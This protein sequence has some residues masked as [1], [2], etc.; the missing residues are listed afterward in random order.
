MSTEKFI[1]QGFNRGIVSPLA[2]ARTDLEKTGLAAE[3]MTNWVPR[4]LGSMML[5]PGGKYLGSSYSDAAARYI[6]FIFS[7]DDVAL[8][9]VTNALVRVW[10]DDAVITRGSVSTTIS[11][12]D[13]SSLTNWTD[14]DESGGTSELFA[15]RALKLTGNGSNAAIR[16]QLVSVSAADGGDEHAVKVIVERGPVNF[17]IGSFKGG[18]DYFSETELE[19]GVHS[20]AFTPDD[21]FY[22][23][24]K[25]VNKY[26][27]LVDS[28]TI[29]S[30][31]AMTITA[32]W[33][34]TDFD[35]IRY[36]QSGDILFI[37]ST[38]QQYKIERRTTRSWSVVKYYSTDGP[39]LD[40]NITETT[41]TPS[42]I[43]G[44]ITL[45]ATDPIFDQILHEGAL[46]RISSSGQSVTGSVTAENQFTNTIR[47]FG[48]GSNRIFTITRSGTWV[49]TVTLQRSLTS[50]TGPWEDVTTYTTNATIT[51]D[52]SFDNQTAW[53]RIGVKTGGFTSGTVAL[54]LSYA[55]GSVDGIVR[56][57]NSN[58]EW[59]TRTSAAD[60]DWL[61]VAW[62][63]ELS[64]FAAVSSTGV[65]NRVMTSPDGIT[66]T[67]R[68]SATDT[69][70]RAVVWS[71]SLALFAA[72]SITGAS[73][74]VMTSSDGITWTTRTSAA[75]NDWHAIA[76]SPSLALFA[77]VSDTGAGNRVM[78]STNG[79]AWTSRTSAADNSWRAIC[80]SPELALFAAVS[81]TGTGNRVMTS[82]DGI[83]W[84]SRT[85]AA[86][87]E[88]RA[89]AWSPELALFAAV[90]SSGTGNRVMTS[91]DG[92]TW[93]SRTS[94]ADNNW[95]GI[96]WS[97]ELSIFSAV[98]ITGT[99]NR[100][101]TSPD[102]ITWT[103]RTSAA[104]NSW[105]AICWSS[106]LSLFATVSYTG[107]GNRVMTTY[108]NQTAKA[109]VLT[110]L[111]DVIATDSW[112]EGA[113]SNYRD[114][115][116]AVAFSEGR[117]WWSGFN[118][119]WG[120]VSDDY[121]NY[122][123]SVEGD[124]GAID[125]TVGS[126]AVDSINWMMALQ[127]LILGTEGAELVCKSSS[128][129]EPL[130]PTAFSLRTASTQGSATVSPAALDRT[131]IYV[132]RGGTRLMEL[133][134]DIRDGE[135]G[136]ID[137]TSLNPEICRP[138]IVRTAIQRQPD[139]RIHCVRSDGKVAILV[140]D[141]VEN[142]KAWCLYETDGA[143]EDVAVLPGIEGESEDHVYYHIKR[144]FPAAT[145][146]T[147]RTPSSNNE[148]YG[149]TWS[150]ELS[151]FAVVS[152]S[153]SS[154]RVMTSPDGITWTSRVSA[155]SNNWTAIAW[156]PELSLF[157]AVSQTGTGNRV[158]TSPD[159]ITWTSRTSAA[160]NQWTAIAWSPE[161]SLFAAVSITGTGNRVMTSSD[162]ITW[163][164][165]T[166]AADNTWT[167]IA[168][169]PSLS[170]FA[171]VSITGT[172]NRVMTS[173]DGITWTS[174][175][176][177]ADNEWRAIA[178]SPE[179][180]L[181]AAVS[182]SGTGNRVMT[183]PDG[184]TWTSRTSA[185]DNNWYGITWS[186]E[187]GIFAAVGSNGTS[188]GVMTSSNGIAWSVRVPPIDNGW[189]SIAW[190]PSLSMFAAVAL[191]GTGSYLMTGSA[192]KRYLERW[193]TEAQCEGST[194][195]RNIDCAIEY[196]GT[197]TTSITGLP[198]E[199]E[200]VVVWA[201]GKDL[202]T[203]TVASGAITLSE[204]TTAA[205]TGLSYSGTWKSVKLAYTPGYTSLL[206][207]KNI[208]HLGVIL[209]NTHYQGLEYGPDF[210]TMDDLPL[211][212]NGVATAADT[213]HS[214]YDEDMFEFPGQWDTDARLCL[215]ATAPKPCNILAAVVGIEIHGKT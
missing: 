194:L 24:F 209:R 40:E 58:D 161:L 91:P 37:A 25:N 196:S 117:L 66:W 21:D 36:D 186:P 204:A 210:T 78:T 206:Q 197:S 69:S 175:T 46:F 152:L 183:S 146:W 10:V 39:W 33:S 187:L 30:S 1:L 191:S 148:W 136:S 38:K 173:S 53:Y 79:T 110:E 14:A 195:S 188:N 124:S 211:I 131:G 97:P 141:S 127:R 61:G 112:A 93:T 145:T 193:Y 89:I 56:L 201:N 119:V 12:G 77:A 4:V 214:T 44:D 190:S 9:E 83:T 139:T 135:Y 84:T 111:G 132:Q 22:I 18:D 215:R 212:E 179:L 81:I 143:V 169:S 184:I 157:A 177:A 178:W 98:S 32:P 180:S 159:G 80:W 198:H 150:P 101:M 87:N 65:G 121:Y 6:P 118:G 182:N 75:D 20:L 176:S 203:Y 64:L 192:D 31:G 60:N 74:R 107:T 181:F 207:K 172:G 126:G 123:D 102:G 63:P 140:F 200:S 52:D 116:S 72:V 151:L 108:G 189:K 144:T 153:G 158:M 104:D 28:C 164:S 165:R 208:K 3:T 155:S 82:P 122:S 50:T 43:S 45:T 13:F 142:V 199:G 174:R 86:D 11:N 48:T 129:D 95:Y 68:T 128:F 54:T 35:L 130:T 19:A 49:A 5:R 29:E 205:I 16:R 137:L 138:K 133:S 73:N 17:M 125:R 76:W 59:T 57:W 42:A 134:I 168:W 23:Q 213:V 162:G 114:W 85:S 105:A 202:G 149:I 100:V 99:G 62:S 92:I 96:A 2:L 103:S 147:T 106:E 26:S 185:A 47:V 115:P 27:V 166:S 67:S 94:A 156:S 109:T 171:A 154:D 70:W 88:W 7:I 163:T 113:W 15:S 8:I 51:Y 90:S 34:T 71:P 55:I 170:L 41:I 160:D 167:A 120:S